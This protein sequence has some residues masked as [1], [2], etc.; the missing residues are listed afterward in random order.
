MTDKKLIKQE[1]DRKYRMKMGE[2][3]RQ[4]KREYYHKNKESI[5]AKAKLRYQQNPEPAKLRAKKWKSDNRARHNYLCMLRHARKLHATPKWLTEL[6]ILGMQELY[7]KSILMKELT[8]IPHEVDHIIPLQ[9][10]DVCGLHVPWNLR[11]ITE[12]ANS[13]KTNNLPD[14]SLRLSIDGWR[15]L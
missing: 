4:K 12:S 1:S 14:E 10:K 15:W 2:I 8:G 6:M 9:G 5:S 13:S 7:S 3:L 11:I